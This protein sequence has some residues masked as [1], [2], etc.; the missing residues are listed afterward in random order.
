[1]TADKKAGLIIGLGFGGAIVVALIVA[2]VIDSI[3]ARPKRGGYEWD[4]ISYGENYQYK[5][6]LPFEHTNKSKSFVPSSGYYFDTPLDFAQMAE[7]F[8]LNANNHAEIETAP[9]EYE[10]ETHQYITLLVFNN[11]VN[12]RFLVTHYNG[13]RFCIVYAGAYNYLPPTP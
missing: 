7:S 10:I 1:M 4:F 6:V 12:Y 11:G 2:M 8:N 3:Q 13:V 9:D 5:L